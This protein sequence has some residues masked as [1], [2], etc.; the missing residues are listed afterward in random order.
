MPAEAVVI[1]VYPARVSR[2]GVKVPRYALKF[3]NLNGK[4]YTQHNVELSDTYKVNDTL[5]VFYNPA[6]PDDPVIDKE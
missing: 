2:Y 6:N 3:A 1:Q 4:E 5:T